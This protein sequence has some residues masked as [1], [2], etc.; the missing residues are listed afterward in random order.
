[1]SM[2][3]QKDNPRA[4]YKH[5]EIVYYYDENYKT[6]QNGCKF[7]VDE[8]MTEDLG[9]NRTYYRGVLNLDGNTINMCAM[10]E[11]FLTPTKK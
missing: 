10:D 9:R 8:S 5:G 3:Y 2:N 7:V 4:K 6:H 11:C 1:M